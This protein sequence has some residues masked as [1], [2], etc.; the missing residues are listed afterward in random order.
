MWWPAGFVKNSGALGRNPVGHRNR[1]GLSEPPGR[2][3]GTRSA[4]AFCPADELSPS[5]AAI[6]ASSVFAMSSL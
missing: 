3:Y 5:A 6:S 2:R 1:A 4:A